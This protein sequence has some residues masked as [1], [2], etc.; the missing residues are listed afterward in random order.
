MAELSLT[1]YLD[2]L[3]TNNGSLDDGVDDVDQHGIAH[4]AEQVDIQAGNSTAAMVSQTRY[5]K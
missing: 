4:D 2:D 5:T 3:S 1:H